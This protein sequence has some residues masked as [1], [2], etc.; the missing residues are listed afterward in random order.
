M[1]RSNL[2][3]VKKSSISRYL[4]IIFLIIFVCAGGFIMLSPQFEQNKPNII[5]KNEIFW[6]LSTKLDIELNDD[7]GIKYYKITYNDGGKEIILNSEILTGYD[8]KLIVS[9]TA[10]KLDMFY[11]GQDVSLDIEVVDNSKWNYLSGNISHKKVKLHID[12]KKPVVNIINNSRYIRRGGSAAVIVKVEDKNLKDSFISFNDKVRFELRP[13]Y[14]DNYFIALLAWDVNIEKFKRVNVIA[15]DKAGNKTITKIPLY[16]QPL[17]V[18]KDIIKIS[19]NFIQSVSS[20]V[21]EQSG[22]VIPVELPKRF[23]EQNRILRKK[24]VQFLR[25]FS[26]K[27]MDKSR[28]DEFNIKPF[29]RLRG[30]RTA[31]GFAEKRSY[32]YKGKKIDEA[33]HLGM[34]WASTKRDTIKTSNDGKVLFNKYLGIYGNTIIIDHKLGLASL[35]AHMSSTN[36]KVGDMV[37]AKDKI[38]RTGST[39]AVMGDHLHFGILIQGIEVNPLEWMDKSWMKHNIINIINNAKQTID[40]N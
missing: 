25:D 38:A 10:P 22:E 35:Y 37:K 17:K 4:I 29:K 5:C 12:I 7:T 15:L 28:I 34:D 21:L 24:N 18:K 1:A 11:K 13:F 36:I 3:K 19:P 40:N 31:T 6:N 8:K 27:H 30:S 39:G 32:F 26:M 16:I 20:N 2:F 33:W 9:V 14:K 23:I